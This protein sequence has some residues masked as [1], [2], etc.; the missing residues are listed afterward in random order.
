MGKCYENI[1]DRLRQWVEQQKMF[2]VATAPRGDQ[3]HVNCSPKGGD[4][5]RITGLRTLAY[6]DIPGSGIE[7]LAH[8]RENGRIVLMLCA[9]DGPPKIVR[10]H[11]M[12]R[13]LN[14]GEAEFAKLLPLFTPQPTVR[15]IIQVDVDRISDSCG[16]GV[17]L[18]SYE[19]S[20]TT[21]ADYVRKMSDDQLRQYGV[22]HNQQ[23][24]DGL[25]GL[26][27]GEAVS[28]VIDRSAL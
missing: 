5:L 8:L 12:G 10:F 4:S 13:V 26:T 25:T 14:P 11:G 24:I 23:S 19:R 18:Y 21:S 2:F 1:D 3:G 6:L 16:F 17:P 28:L 27:A 20:R 15:A 22:D 9:F 7:T